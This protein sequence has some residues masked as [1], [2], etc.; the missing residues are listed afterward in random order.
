M[1]PR[2]SRSIVRTDFDVCLPYLGVCVRDER[3]KNS[4]SVPSLE[5]SSAL[6]EP[7]ESALF[8]YFNS[9]LPLFS[10]WD[11]SSDLTELGRTPV[12]VVCA[13]VKSV[14]DIPRTLEV[15][16]S[17]LAVVPPSQLACS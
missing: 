11:V 2:E 3:H 17:T 9:P 16:V 7:S 4:L 5:S 1:L 13:G 8:L 12:A 15:L 6:D 10:A 14:L